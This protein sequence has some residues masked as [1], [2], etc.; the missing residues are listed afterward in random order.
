VRAVVLGCWGV[1]FLFPF[2][3]I[4]TY[5][6][7]YTPVSMDSQKNVSQKVVLYLVLFFFSFYI[8][9]KKER[10][11]KMSSNSPNARHKKSANLLFLGLSESPKEEG[12]VFSSSASICIFG[13]SRVASVEIPIVRVRA[14]F[15]SY[16][17][18]A[19]K[20]KIAH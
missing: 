10:N 12:D 17:V 15:A 19:N 9:R 5:V 13:R 14:S 2:V 3:D 4:P 1:L 16:R 7:E 8:L 11:I 18:F 20:R 6:V